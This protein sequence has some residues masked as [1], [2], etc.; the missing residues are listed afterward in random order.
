MGV[1]DSQM[2]CRKMGVMFQNIPDGCCSPKSLPQGPGLGCGKE[3]RG[4]DGK[5]RGS[6]RENTLKL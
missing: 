4:R 5:E 2:I 6:R 1:L 3:E